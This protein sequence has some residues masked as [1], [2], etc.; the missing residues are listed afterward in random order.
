MN[1][2]LLASFF[3]GSPKESLLFR[4]SDDSGNVRGWSWHPPGDVKGLIIDF[5]GGTGD[6]GRIRLLRAAGTGIGL[7]KHGFATF[8]PEYPKMDTHGGPEDRSFV[9][10]SWKA[11]QSAHP[12]LKPVGIYGHSRGGMQAWM[13]G[14]DADL[15]VPLAMDCPLVDMAAS[16][17][18]RPDLEGMFRGM[19]LATLEEIR[20][21]TPDA[22]A[23][24][25]RHARVLLQ[26]CEADE[27]VPNAEIERLYGLL[28][29]FGHN[30]TL[31][32]YP[33]GHCSGGDAALQDAAAIF[34]PT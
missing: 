19:G 22:E 25:K 20:R 8:M 11:F 10:E 30:A 17:K 3:P 18:M 29:G 16:M 21:R 1:K 7:E 31:K 34:S 26:L 23:I 12:Q 24:G 32:R 13:F 2:T 9:L 4:W 5:R 27:K 15:R 14:E 33:G 6:F 28:Q